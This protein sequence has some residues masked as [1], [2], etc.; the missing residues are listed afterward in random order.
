MLLLF[1]GLF[2]L[3]FGRMLQI[4][5][6]GQIDGRAL[7]AMADQKYL[8]ESVLRADRG[9]IVDR[10]GE[11]I[12]TDTLSYRLIAVLSEKATKGSK[13]QLHVTDFEQTAEVLSK[14]IDMD[15]EEILERFESASPDAYQVEFGKAGRSISNETADAI[16]KEEL[17]GIRFFEDKKRLYPNGNF[18]SYLV[19]FAMPEKTE[20]DSVETIGKMGLE[21]TYNK[22]LTG[23]DGKADFKTDR[24]GIQLRDT[25]KNIQAP[26]DG[27]TIQLTLDK[28][29]QNFVED[30]LNRAEK[31]YSPEKMMAVVVNPKTGEILAMSQRPSFHPG[32]REGLTENWLNEA[33]EETF[34]PGSTMK[35]FTLAAAIQEN[36]W[37]PNAYYKS[38]QYKIYDRTIRDVNRVGWGMI[39]FLEGFQ[40]SSNV[41]M[42]YLLERLGDQTLIEYFEEFGFGKKVGIDLPNEAP[43]VLLANFPSERLTTSYGQ[44]ST[45]TPIQMVQA[46]TAIANDGKMMT[47]Y[48]IDQIIDPNKD[49]VVEKHEP[50]EKKSPI[51]EDTAKQVREILAST[52][53]SEHGTGKKFAL[54]GYDAGGKT[55]TAQIPKTTG[56]GY[57]SGNGNYLYSF[58]GM[59]PIDDP[60]LL[61]Y[62]LVQKPKLKEGKYGS[63]P[64]SEIFTSVMESSLKYLNIAPDSKQP[65]ASSV[66]QDY[67]GETSEKVVAELT[68]QGMKPIV[69]G[70]PGE[71]VQQSPAAKTKLTKGSI[72]LLKT[73][74]ETALPNF[75]GWSKKQVMVFKSFSGLDIRLNGEGFVVKQSLSKGASVSDGDP[76]VITLQDPEQSNQTKPEPE[77]DEEPEII[78]G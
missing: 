36:R 21:K 15:K 1:G 3:L 68:E 30:A 63:D 42:A 20:G 49:E 26:Q 29:I 51:S 5:V 24:W 32:T 69:V 53:T 52:I 65:D 46:A 78:G 14:Y 70:Q 16:K 40:R 4:Q 44:G 27:Q 41:S 25:K 7:A 17:P 72:V 77:P 13:K 18:A 38:G 71:V 59:A 23:T 11:V 48:V 57:I 33:V 22:Q 12:A 37:D 47:P 31:E 75:T 19:G 34:E 58:L 28:T 60:Q 74:G 2:F 45:V 56:G 66:I 8:K 64:T 67:Q 73:S 76:I 61:T 10:A 62:V 54:D 50:E 9:K 35:M 43:G 6:T 55:G 39:T